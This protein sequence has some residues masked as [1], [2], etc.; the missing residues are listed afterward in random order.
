MEI[1]KTTKIGHEHGV[2]IRVA[3][4]IV[5]ASQ[6]FSCDIH[7]YRANNKDLLINA[8]A[9]LDLMTAGLE[10]GEEVSIFCNGEDATKAAE[11]MEY[12]FSANFD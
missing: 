12:V 1:T 11:V 3:T 9:I 4:E 10:K 7:V 2:H 6:Q 8:K 5:K